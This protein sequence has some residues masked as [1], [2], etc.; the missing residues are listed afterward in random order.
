MI[1]D[2][3]NLTFLD[4]RPVNVQDKRRAVAYFTGGIAAE[5]AEQQKIQDEKSE[6]MKAYVRDFKDAREKA[7]ERVRQKRAALG[8]VQ[9]DY[10]KRKETLEQKR[11]V[12][13]EEI[14]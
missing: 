7:A 5:R 8:L 14:R 4:D 10:E 2:L 3:P 12:L 11:D 1:N 9:E 13:K 6:R